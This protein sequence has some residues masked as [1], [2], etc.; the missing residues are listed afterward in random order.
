MAT[1]GPKRKPFATITCQHCGKDFEA[2]RF[3]EWAPG[4]FRSAGFRKTR[5]CSV[6]CANY[7]RMAPPKGY[8]H[9]TG[10]RYF[11]VAGPG[12]SKS[13]AEHRMVMEKMLGRKLTKQETVHHKNGDRLDNRPE[14]LELWASRHG[15]GQRVSDLQPAWKLGAAYLAGVLV[16]KSNIPLS[17]WK[18]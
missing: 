16:A 6:S 3:I 2:R 9:H 5:Y 7:A 14:N 10:Y 18:D 1:R 12:R 4:R 11:S 13:V 8:V 17:H 15:R